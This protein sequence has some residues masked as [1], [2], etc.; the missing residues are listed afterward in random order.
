MNQNIINNVLETC[1]D[2]D[3]EIKSKDFTLDK[4]SDFI[5]LTNKIITSLFDSILI[6]EFVSESINKQIQ[7]I[8]D[9]L[10]FFS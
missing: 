1:N 5:P 6:G 3:K 8:K 4:V 9:S 2:I 10:V 7:K